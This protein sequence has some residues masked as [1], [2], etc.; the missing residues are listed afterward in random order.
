MVVYDEYPIDVSRPAAKDN[1]VYLTPGGFAWIKI[2][3]RWICPALIV[4]VWLRDLGD[5][6]DERLKKSVFWSYKDSSF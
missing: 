3:L 2:F 6:A 4:L 5:E 1:D